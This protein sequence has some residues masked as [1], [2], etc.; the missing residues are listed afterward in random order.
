[1]ETPPENIDD[2]K[3][4]LADAERRTAEVKQE[5][6]EA[7]DLIHRMQEQV[8][9]SSAVIDRWVEAFEM[10]LN[11][12]GEWTW[13]AGLMERH[14]ALV[15]RYNAL[16]RDWNKFVRQY[17]AAIAPKQIGRPLDASP[18]QCAQVLKLRNGKGR[19][20]LRGIAEETGLTLQTVRTILDKKDGTDRATTNRLKRIDPD[21]ATEIS[22]RARKRTIDALPRQINQTLKD[23]AALRKEAKG[24]A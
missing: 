5:R 11:A 1:M 2:L 6:D 21:R 17:N 9:D 24:L 22:W 13:S 18:A 10:Q 7:R 8:E 3:A 20:S 12:A 4:Q 16:L 14:N 15:E 23:G 19:K